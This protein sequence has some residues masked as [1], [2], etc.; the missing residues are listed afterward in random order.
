M[1]NGCEGSMACPAE[2]RPDKQ[3]ARPGRP[4]DEPLRHD[5]AITPDR[6]AVKEAAVPKQSFSFAAERMTMM[7]KG[8]NVVKQ[9]DL[10]SPNPARV[11]RGG[12][13]ARGE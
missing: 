7:N 12:G 6:Q 9:K 10:E 5:K 13:Q 2:V 11:T 4:K 3:T 8:K 1:M